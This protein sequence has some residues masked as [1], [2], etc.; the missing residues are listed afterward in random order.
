MGSGFFSAAVMLGLSVFALLQRPIAPAQRRD[1]WANLAVHG[2][3]VAVVAAW[4]PKPAEVP[5]DLGAAGHTLVHCLSWPQRFFTPWGAWVWL[6]FAVFALSHLSRR[7]PSHSE[8]MILA[9]GGW[10]LLQILAISLRR[11]SPTVVITPRY[12]EIFWLGLVANTLALDAWI[13]RVGGGF[14]S[15]GRGALAA[16]AAVWLIVVI[17]KAGS[18]AES[19]RRY[20]LPAYEAFATSQINTV[21]AFLDTGKIASLQSAAYPY[22][23]HPDSVYL[24]RMLA[25]PTLRS[26]LPTELTGHPAPFLERAA[27]AVRRSAIIWMAVALILFL[28]ALSRPRVLAEAQAPAN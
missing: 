10:V 28:C 15:I 3:I 22:V 25:N 1:A 6:P 17:T 21:R 5:F 9:L 14:A 23:P 18:F 12:Y 27:A 8:W 20:D 16:S 24:A 11:N 19:H 13:R 7:R 2:A 4:L 26:V